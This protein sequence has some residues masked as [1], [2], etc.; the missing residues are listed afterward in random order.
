M[1]PFNGLLTIVGP[2]F[3][4]GESACRRCYLVRRAAASGYDADF[5][6]LQRI[7][8]AAAS[9][10]PIAVIAASL[11]AVLT[12]RWLTLR[13]PR[14]PGSLYAFEHTPIL[15]LTHHRVLRVPRCP[16]CGPYDRVIP[17]LWFDDRS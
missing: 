7:P 15:R 10:V 2:L 1:L 16:A 12:L 13:D 11:A 3:L 4:P 5:E 14:L 6:R 17:S 8:V 9:P